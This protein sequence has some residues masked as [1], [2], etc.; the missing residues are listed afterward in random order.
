MRV[1]FYGFIT[2]F[3]LWTM[4]RKLRKRPIWTK[5]KDSKEILSK[6]F[7]FI[8]LKIQCTL[9]PSYANMTTKCISFF[10]DWIW[11]RI[12]YCPE[13]RR[14]MVFTSLPNRTSSHSTWIRTQSHQQQEYEHRWISTR[15]PP[16]L[17][18]GN[19]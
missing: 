15:I 11:R 7:H 2:I 9:F 18:F 12:W 3:K 19:A 8:S 17:T 14:R 10:A 4:H 6:Q 1:D 13:N 5:L 16:F